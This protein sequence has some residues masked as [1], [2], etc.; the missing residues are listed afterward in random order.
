MA[1]DDDVTDRNSTAA[2]VWIDEMPL[3]RIDR[4]TLRRRVIAVP[5]DAVFLPDGSTFQ[6]NLDPHDEADAAA[7]TSV[8]EAVGLLT[9]VQARGGLT[10]GMTAGTFSQGQRQLFSLARAVLRRRI[11][12][13]RSRD[14]VGGVEAG[15]VLLLDEVSS[16]VDRETERVMLDIIRDEFR[17]YTVVAVSH[18][19]E[20]VMDF[21]RVVAMD[22]GAVVEVGPPRVLAADG[23]TRFG[24]LWRAGGT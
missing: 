9:L 17:A 23:E 24:E 7:C 12:A 10:A 6:A 21:D 4:A 11:R 18:R 8:L 13:R 22:T 16:S 19:L 3:A 1:G 2:G 5:Q 20:M 15:G 14:S